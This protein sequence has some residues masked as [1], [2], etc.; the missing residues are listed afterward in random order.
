[1]YKK[2]NSELVRKG[3]MKSTRYQEGE[4]DLEIRTYKHLMFFIGKITKYF[5]IMNQELNKKAS[6]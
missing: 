5:C 3:T 4:T 6:L 1:M 2:I